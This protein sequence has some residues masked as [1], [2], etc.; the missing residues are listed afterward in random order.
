VLSDG[1]DLPTVAG[2]P[3]RGT[4]DWSELHEVLRAIPEGKWTTYGDL[5][6]VVGTAAQPLGQHVATCTLCP[7]AHRVLGADGRPRPNFAWT[8]PTDTRTQQE[9]LE[10]EGVPFVDG[11]ADPAGRLSADELEALLP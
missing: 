1:R 7:N 6:A 3:E 5:A 4:F 8:D 10:A 2:V 9:A 11:V